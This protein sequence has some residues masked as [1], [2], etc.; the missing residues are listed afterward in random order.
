MSG[1]RMDSRSDEDDVRVRPT[2]HGSRPRTRTRPAHE[3]AVPGVVMAVDRG[4]MTVR[5]LASLAVAGA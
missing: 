4:R 2:R 5:V 3:E 1:R